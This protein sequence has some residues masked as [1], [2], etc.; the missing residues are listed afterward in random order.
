MT[1]QWIKSS[2]EWGI[3]NSSDVME[4]NQLLFASIVQ[5][6]YLNLRRTNT[7]CRSDEESEALVYDQ[8]KVGT[9]SITRLQETC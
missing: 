4:P 1:C 8:G 3:E 7:G 5:S 9:L 2:I 6:A